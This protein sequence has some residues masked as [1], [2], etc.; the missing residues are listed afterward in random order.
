MDFIDSASA[1][2]AFTIYELN[3][4]PA[5]RRKSLIWDLDRR[6]NRASAQ[7]QRAQRHLVKGK[8]NDFDDSWQNRN[9]VYGRPD[10]AADPG[11]GQVRSDIYGESKAGS[12]GYQMTNY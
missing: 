2:P 6:K 7:R 10:G 9:Q 3:S 5:A 4:T 11:R 8:Y 12:G 1:C